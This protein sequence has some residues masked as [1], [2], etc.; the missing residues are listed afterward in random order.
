MEMALRFL[1]VTSALLLDVTHGLA[2]GG[3]VAA[4]S[5][6]PLLSRRALLGAASAAAVGAAPLAATA[7][8]QPMLDKPVD[9]FAPAEEK[10]QAFLAKQKVFKKAWRKQLANLEFSSNDQEALEAIVELSNLINKNGFE[11]P[12]GVRKMDLDQVRA[13]TRSSCAQGSARDSLVPCAHAGV[14]DGA[15]EARQADAH[16]VQ[17]AGRHG[18][19]D[20]DRQVDGRRARYTVLGEPS[21]ALPRA[22][23][24]SE[25]LPA[26]AVT[27]R[28]RSLA[29]RRERDG[30]FFFSFL[31][32]R[33]VVLTMR[34]GAVF[35]FP[36]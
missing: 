7:N 35:S 9:S 10:R 27:L 2:L 30:Y 23:L 12:E 22:E 21:H 17:E 13:R 24:P 4:S 3:D 31:A 20:R 14:Q 16:G 5:R 11:I 18:A 36:I 29:G 6:S 34:I 8:T 28:R 19:A 32:A 25:A 26:R 1:L 33:R 15:G